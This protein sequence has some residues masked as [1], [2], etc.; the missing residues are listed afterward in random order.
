MV[1]ILLG[2]IRANREGDGSLH[3]ACIRALIPWCFAMGKM[4]YS[5]YLPFF[6]AQISRLHETYPDLHDTFQRGGFSVQMSHSNPF[7]LI[8]VD[9]T[10]EE[11]VNEDTQTAGGTRG[12]SLSFLLFPHS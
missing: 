2:L 8:A 7:A 1:E 5:R 10:T 4:N 11:T 12:F 9:Q 3:L 6:Y